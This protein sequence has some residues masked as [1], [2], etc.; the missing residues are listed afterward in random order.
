MLVPVPMD[1]RDGW[2]A[3]IDDLDVDYWI[4]PPRSQRNIIDL[5][6]TRRYFARYPVTGAPLPFP[7]TVYFEDQGNRQGINRTLRQMGLDNNWK[8]NVVI[9]RNVHE[10]EYTTM[11]SDDEHVVVELLR[12][13]V[14]FYVL[15]RGV[16]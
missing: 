10:E 5:T 11:D 15:T 16:R 3:S 1:V 14:Y 2:S 8:G 7:C 6:S 13:S 9:V 4:P 12:Q